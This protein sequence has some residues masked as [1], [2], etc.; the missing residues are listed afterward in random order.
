[1]NT[2]LVQTLQNKEYQK[3]KDGLGF[4]LKNFPCKCYRLILKIFQSRFRI[5]FE[6]ELILHWNDLGFLD[7]QDH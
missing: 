2:K 4:E 3:L 1:M 7:A 6:L 5:G